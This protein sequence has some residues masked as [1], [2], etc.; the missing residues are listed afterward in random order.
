MNMVSNV[1]SK[2]PPGTDH[3]SV[4]L[5]N[6]SNLFT[7]IWNERRTCFL[8]TK[9][10]RKNQA[11]K[12]CNVFCFESCFFRFWPLFSSSLFLIF[13]LFCSCATYF[14][15]T[16]SGSGSRTLCL[17]IIGT[18]P[19]KREERLVYSLWKWLVKRRDGDM[20]SSDVCLLF[21]VV[22]PE[23]WLIYNRNVL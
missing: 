9:D 12:N 1:V 2:V 11:P 4:T 19:W 23:H 20:C 8:F 6:S 15:K 3:E 5:C 10:M 7:R 13:L 14:A 22:P 17:F 16:F 21:R 18:Y